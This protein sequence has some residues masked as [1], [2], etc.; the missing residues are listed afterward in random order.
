MQV[1]GYSVLGDH[2]QLLGMIE[3]L[4]MRL[5]RA[6]TPPARRPSA[7]RSSNAAAAHDIMLLSCM[8][9]KP[10][11]AGILTCR[12]ATPAMKLSII[13]VYNEGRRSAG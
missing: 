6:A 11:S 7:R 8:H 1:G 3:A 4:T 13:P 9:L 12:F 5:R 2:A 10:L